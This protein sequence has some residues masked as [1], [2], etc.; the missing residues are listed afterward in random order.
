[1]ALQNTDQLS[2][3]VYKADAQVGLFPFKTGRI[4]RLLR[5]IVGFFTRYFHPR[6]DLVL[7]KLAH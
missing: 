7:E 5:L 1:M 3:Q 6:N 4:P 2:N